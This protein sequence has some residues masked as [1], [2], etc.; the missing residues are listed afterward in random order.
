MAHSSQWLAVG[1]SR[2][3]RIGVDIERLKPRKNYPA[4]AGILGW[5]EKV[6]DLSDFLSKWTLWEAGAKCIGSSSL[7]RP[8]A[9]FE[10]L[11]YRNADGRV[12]SLGRWNSLHDRLNQDTYYAIV[13]NSQ[14][15]AVLTHRHLEPA[16]IE[17]W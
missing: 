3:A 16:E 9:E 7:A 8:N 12:D 5:K 17:P 2:G 6:R 4:M 11:D 13:L 10:R 14:H 15:G 1:L